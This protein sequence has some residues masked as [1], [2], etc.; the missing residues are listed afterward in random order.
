MDRTLT[1]SDVEIDAAWESAC[2]LMRERGLDVDEIVEAA[3][4][5]LTHCLENPAPA[6]SE[7]SITALVDDE[8]KYGA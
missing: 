4:R 8:M 2:D 5:R 3:S 6:P 1:F 7:E